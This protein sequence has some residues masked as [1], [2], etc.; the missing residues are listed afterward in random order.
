[1]S[2]MRITEKQRAAW[3]AVRLALSRARAAGL[4]WA[5]CYGS[6]IPYDRSIVEDIRPDGDGI[7][8]DSVPDFFQHEIKLGCGEMADDPHFII[9]KAGV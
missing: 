3:D 7:L 5:N 2:P 4:G 1:M 6:L 9:M 8:H